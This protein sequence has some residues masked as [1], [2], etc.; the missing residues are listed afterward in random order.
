METS[1]YVEKE[2]LWLAFGLSL[3]AAVGVGLFLVAGLPIALLEL[4]LNRRK[5][6]TLAPP[7]C[8]SNRG[9]LTSCATLRHT[10]A[11]PLG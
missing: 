8:S 11:G 2:T 9:A 6:D 5:S 3:G 7:L 4:R 10:L 1:A